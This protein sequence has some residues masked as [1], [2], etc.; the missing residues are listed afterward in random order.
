[1]YF[2]DIHCGHLKS[3]EIGFYNVSRSLAVIFD[4]HDSH[5]LESSFPTVKGKIYPFQGIP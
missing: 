1:M 4:D 5:L 3:E 2:I